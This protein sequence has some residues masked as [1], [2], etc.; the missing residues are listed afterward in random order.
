VAEAAKMLGKPERTV[1]YWCETGKLLAIPKPYG[2]K[3]TYQISP[4]AILLFQSSANAHPDKPSEAG[5]SPQKTSKPH[6]SYLKP[7]MAAMEKGLINGRSFSPHTIKA[8]EYYVL[9]FLSQHPTL[10]I[11]SLKIALAAISVDSVSVKEKLYKSLVCF[12]KF[13][14]R[15]GALEEAFLEQAKPLAPKYHKPPN[16]YT[17]PPDDIDSLLIACETIQE[18]AILQLLVHTGLRA[19]ELCSLTPVDLDLEEGFLVVQCDKGGKRR[20][21]GLTKTVIEDL[22]HYLMVQQPAET[23]PLFRNN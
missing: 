8:Y 12:A 20:R 21:V 5:S 6:V 3:V 14:I 9:Q 11:A 7:W 22:R 15:E 13:L 23:A 1:R 10:S 19:A 16:R 2:R 18:R 17:V 4:Q